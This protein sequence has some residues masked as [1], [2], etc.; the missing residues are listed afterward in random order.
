MA[1]DTAEIK[2]KGVRGIVNKELVPFT[3]QLASMTGAGMS[4]LSTMQTLEEQA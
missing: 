1:N 4:I 2:V 3:K